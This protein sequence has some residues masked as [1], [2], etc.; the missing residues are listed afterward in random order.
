MDFPDDP[1]MRVSHEMIYLSLFV[2]SRGALR[3]DLQRQLR[4]GRAMRHPRA[5]RLP[6]GRGQL[7]DTVGISERPA[8]AE[9]RA[10][11][12]ALGGRP[13]QGR[14]P[15]AV[16]TLVERHSRF[17]QLFALPD[18][19]RADQVRPALTTSITRLPGPAA[20]VP[21]LAQL[22]DV[23]QQQVHHQQGQ[24]LEQVRVP[25]QLL[26]QVRVRRGSWSAKFDGAAP[27]RRC[28]PVPIWYS[29][30]ARDQP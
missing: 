11:P 23:D 7:R 1:G 22:L 29:N 10:R 13:G 18:G 19:W 15:S 4:T 17:V 25:D 6:Q 28:S 12:R 26:G 20:P 21:D 5:A 8:E 27:T 30:T 16:G 14:R 24:V 2:Q 9:D 3:R